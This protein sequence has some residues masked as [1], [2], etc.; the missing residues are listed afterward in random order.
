MDERVRFNYTAYQALP[1][2]T[3]LGG[4]PYNDIPC[5]DIQSPIPYL[6]P[7]VLFQFW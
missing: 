1:L 2:T 6:I 7:A 4:V 5:L 3:N